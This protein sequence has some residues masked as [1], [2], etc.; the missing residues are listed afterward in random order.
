[1]AA[2]ACRTEPG[3]VQRSLVHRAGGGRT[4]DPAGQHFS[5][6]EAMHFHA[7]LAPEPIDVPAWSKAWP[8]DFAT[9]LANASTVFGSASADFGAASLLMGSTA[10]PGSAG[11]G[12]VASR[13]AGLLLFV[14]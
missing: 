14:C 5:N 1:M 3:A 7:L 6:S 8:D 12:E 2:G 10:L 13:A 11:R 9:D 4:A